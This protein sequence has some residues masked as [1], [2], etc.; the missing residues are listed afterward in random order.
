MLAGGRAFTAASAAGINFGSPAGLTDLPASGYTMGLAVLRIT[1]D[2]NNQY[3]MAKTGAT[4]TRGVSFLIGYR[5]LGGTNNPRH[6]RVIVGTAGTR[7]DVCSGNADGVGQ[8]P[9]NQHSIVGWMW[10][11]GA[12]PK[13]YQSAFETK[14]TECANYTDTMSGTSS[15][16]AGSDAGDNK[17]VFN[18]TSGSFSLNGDGSW[19]VEYNRATIYSDEDRWTIQAGLLAFTAGDTTRG[20]AMMK[21][22]TGHK[23]LCFVAND[24]TVTD[25]S[26]NAYVP[27]VSL[28][29]TAAGATLNNDSSG[30]SLNQLFSLTAFEDDNQARTGADNREQTTY[31]Y[32]DS[33]AQKRFTTAATTVTLWGQGT[34]ATDTYAAQQA[35]GVYVEGTGY[36][37]QVLSGRS[38]ALGAGP[39]QGSVAGMA[40]TSKTLCIIN[41]MGS[42]R[43]AA[44]NATEPQQGV[45]GTIA[46]FS[47]SATEIAARTRAN[48]IR[49]LTDSLWLAM[50]ATPI[51]QYGAFEQYRRNLPSFFDAVEHVGYGGAMLAPLTV[52][53]SAI[54]AT[55]AK[56]TY[57]NPRVIFIALGVNDKNNATMNAATF[58]TKLAALVDACLATTSFT[59][60][61]VLVSPIITGASEGGAAGTTMP[62]FRTAIA[63]VQSTRTSRVDYINGYPVVSIGNLAPD[64]IHVVNAGQT[65][66]LAALTTQFATAPARIGSMST[67]HVSVGC[68]I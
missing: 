10:T 68:G 17:V 42:R 41:G 18:N 66:L 15:G 60:R 67:N 9:S 34:F 59:G 50:V 65:E 39:F 14:I 8:L 11:P 12:N 64:N 62:E 25:Y 61:I 46:Y 63:T 58:G 1:S 52:D 55:A 13:L 53:S 48:P 26:D 29:A 30:A 43:V 37:G 3:I 35:L 20:I 5:T 36:A 45:F 6:L 49:C 38:V 51:H 33:F 57:A 16:A 27:T 40:G 4:T 23:L 21:S 31:R 54:A 7:W 2:A 47:A 32:A 44:P 24:G 28:G 22:I 19:Y 56:L